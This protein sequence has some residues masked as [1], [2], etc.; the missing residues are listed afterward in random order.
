M[1]EHKALPFDQLHK[2]K[3]QSGLNS[4]V[5]ASPS[6]RGD[7]YYAT[8]TGTLYIAN[9]AGD[10]WV[11]KSASTSLALLDDV[12]LTSPS[13]GDALV[14]DSVSSV[15]SEGIP[16]LHLIGSDG[17]GSSSPAELTV[18]GIGDDYDFLIVETI[19]RITTNYTTTPSPNYYLSIQ[20]NSSNADDGQYVHYDSV[21]G[22]ESVGQELGDTAIVT[23]SSVA[24]QGFYA[25]GTYYILNHN[26]FSATTLL[27]D[28]FLTD[29]TY[30]IRRKIQLSYGGLGANCSSITIDSSSYSIEKGSELL[31]YGFRT[32]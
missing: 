28:S 18:S 8:D 7:S 32:S 31:V 12:S 16:G 15:F 9:S 14:Y 4:A 10:G 24:P 22:S 2:A 21:A 23:A 1:G 5:P 20:I 25:Y 27:G 3:I 17:N 6:G 11:I 26:Q 30:D 13:D 19:M 29:G